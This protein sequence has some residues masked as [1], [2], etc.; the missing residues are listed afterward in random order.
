MANSEPSHPSTA[1]K[2][3]TKPANLVGQST[4]TPEITSKL[5]TTDTTDNNMQDQDDY[6]SYFSSDEEIEVELDPEGT[7]DL[8]KSYNRQKRIQN[9]LASNDT[10]TL[11]KTNSQTPKNGGRLRIDDHILALSKHAS[12][13]R[14]EGEQGFSSRGGK[15]KSDRATS[16]QVLDPRTRMILLQ[17]LNRALISEISGCLSTGKE[18]NVYHALSSPSPETPHAE[19]LH[20]AVKIF[21]TSILVFKDRAQYVEGEHRFRRGYNKSNNRAMVKVWAEKEMRNLRRLHG[22]GVPCPEP[23]Y[24]RAH[25]LV[26]GFLGTKKGW[27]APRLRDAD[28]EGV[29]AWRKVYVQ[30][31]SYM[32]LMFQ[33]CKLVHADLSEYNLLWHEG[34]AW[35]I[36]VSQSVE[37]DHPRSLEF[38]RMDIKN[39][40]DFFA[41]KEVATL[42]HRVAFDFIMDAEGSFDTED[43][44]SRVDE[45]MANRKEEDEEDETTQE[46]FRQQFIPQNLQQVVDPERDARTIGLGKGDELVYKSL[47]PSNQLH[48]KEVG[49]DEDLGSDRGSDSSV[50]SD[51]D[52]EADDESI[53]DKKT[54][55]G[56]RFEDKEAKKVSLLYP[57][58]QEHVA[59]KPIGA[60]KTSQGREARRTPKED[61]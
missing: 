3:S 59:H 16:E 55:R 10:T 54:P 45:L 15:D 6:D 61:A 13:I 31:L 50:D 1:S 19:P 25:V 46:V 35:V 5:D 30:V 34:K 4:E 12:K 27:P 57:F 23:V 36:D 37:H 60:Q 56:K 18:A 48:E 51:G 44:A 11:P 24:L 41:R 49:G 33:K 52:G 20:R 53:F 39:I 32:R 21:K 40:S 43:M 2:S 8:T 47:L 22:S 14:L 29:A 7:G 42:G 38:L 28:L 58:L 26:M 9:A 17:M